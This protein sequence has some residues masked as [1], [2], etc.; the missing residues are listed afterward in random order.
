ML[1]FFSNMQKKLAVETAWE[2]GYVHTLVH[3]YRR[4]IHVGVGC[5]PVNNILAFLPGHGE[6]VPSS[7]TMQIFRPS[8]F[9][10]MSRTTLLFLL[11]IISSYQSP[12]YSIHTTISPFWLLVVSLWW[13]SF[14]TTTWM[15]PE[16]EREVVQIMVP[17]FRSWQGVRSGAGWRQTLNSEH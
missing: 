13:A 5:V 6:N 2:P 15:L 17:G 1:E 12:L 3:V 11:L 4:G 9:H 10:L 8:L 7:Y 14:H 16:G